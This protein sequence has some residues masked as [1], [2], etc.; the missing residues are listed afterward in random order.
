MELQE[1]GTK[2]INLVDAKTD[3]EVSVHIAVRTIDTDF[4]M[5]SIGQHPAIP[6]DLLEPL[7]DRGL[8]NGVSNAIGTSG[9]SGDL[10]VDFIDLNFSIELENLSDN[11]L[12]D[13]TRGLRELAEE[14]S[15][16]ALG[17]IISS[18]SSQ[19]AG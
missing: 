18:S 6:D 3:V 9:Y 11:D 8:S 5:A 16:Q 7:W 10:E 14:V 17:K 13:L 4:N 19:S 2:T 12:Q 15:A 1:Q